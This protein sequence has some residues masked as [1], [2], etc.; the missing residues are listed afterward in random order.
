MYPAAGAGAGAGAMKEIS[1]KSNNRRAVR[2]AVKPTM[3]AVPSGRR[4]R[5][6]GDGDSLMHP[7]RPLGS[8]EFVQALEGSMRRRLTPQK[9]GRPLKLA[10]TLDRANWPLS[11]SRLRST[12][13]LFIA[14][15]VTAWGT[16]C[17]SPGCSHL[18][19]CQGLITGDC[20]GN[21]CFRPLRNQG[22]VAFVNHP[23]AFVSG[24]G[25]LS[26][27]TNWSFGNVGCHLA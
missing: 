25:E 10:W 24:G 7:Y 5:I 13:R 21:I 11:Q 6:Q 15:V 27:M 19:V 2:T 16:S 4:D 8:A 20:N 18:V 14:V 17:R 3:A 1:P 9:G 26:W 22:P 23:V 12:T